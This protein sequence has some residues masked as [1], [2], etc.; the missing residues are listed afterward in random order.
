MNTCRATIVIALL[1]A[2]FACPGLASAQE[3]IIIG[4][5]SR[6]M[7]HWRQRS[8]KGETDYRIV[9]KDDKAVLEA[10]ADGTASALYRRLRVDLTK[11]PYL[12]WTW[13]VDETFEDID[14]R[15]K[16]GDDYPARIYVVRRGGMA[17]WRTWALNYV[18]SSNQPVDSRWP[19]AYAGENVQMWAVDS[20]TEKAGEWV[21]HVRDV[22]ADFKA[23][24]GM[25]ITEI[26]GVALMTDADDTGSS[27]RAWYGSIRFSDSRE[28][29]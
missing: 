24:F 22:R 28:A 26:D 15:T 21:T 4:D 5:F 10:H 16:A 27:A 19:N 13:R 14:E 11:T 7:E 8:F 2:T 17:F 23:A 20:G 3:E 29:P 18:W 9:T 12:H 1:A 6:G 25:D